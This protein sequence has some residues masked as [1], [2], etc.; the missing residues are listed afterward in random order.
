MLVFRDLS[1]SVRGDDVRRELE[2]LCRAERADRLEALLGA[3]DLECALEDAKHAGAPLARTLSDALAEA[4]LGKEASSMA[5]ALELLR[6]L[7]LPSELRLRRPEGFAFYA[8]DPRA[9][10]H[11]ALH[12][13]S[14]K[15]PVCVVGVRTIGTS[16]SAIVRASLVLGGVPACRITVRPGGHPWDRR[17]SLDAREAQRVRAAAE[18]SDFVIVD[19]GPG[20][21]GSTFLAVGEAL[22]AQGVPASRV[23]FL[24]SH[25][26]VPERLL[27]KDAARRFAPFACRA[28]VGWSPPAGAVDFSGGAWRAHAR[29]GSWPPSWRLQ[30]RAKYFEPTHGWF[31]KF[32]GFA[33]Y[34]RVV[35]ERAGLLADAGYGPSVTA[36]E[37]GFLGYRWV[38]GRAARARRDRHRSLPF[39]AEY[40]AF[41]ARELGADLTRPRELETMTAVNVHEALGVHLP[42]SFELDVRTPVI[43]DGRMLPHE[44]V[45]TDAGA[46]LKTD[47][48]D[49]GDD[50]FFPGP[51]DIAWDLAGAVIEWDLDPSERGALCAAFERASGDRVAHR[52]PA[53]EIA[54]GAFR[55]GVATFAVRDSIEEDAQRW[56]RARH[57]YRERLRTALDAL[58]VCAPRSAS[59]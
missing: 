58:G 12:V 19:E 53:Y 8:L 46:L 23:L 38:Q 17:L 42:P 27:A 37:A 39:M 4:W 13:V 7:T 49:H 59:P 47:G 9:Y 54:Y 45:V 18:D 48:A 29:L 6:D 3:A 22:R 34:G 57:Y 33:P 25:P 24:T 52:L 16:L 55:L 14:G 28:V 15:R 5:R 30:E 31:Y 41:R 10:A 32:S 20:L 11:A 2:R 36:A 56:R 21:S 51:V 35:S 44:W 26:V 43:V 1:C 40:A 50:H